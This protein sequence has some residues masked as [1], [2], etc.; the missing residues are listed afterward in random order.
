MDASSGLSRGELL[1]WINTTLNMHLHKIEETASGA[2]ACQIID[3]LYPDTVPL[4]RVNF[5]AKDAYEYTKNYKILQSACL[6]NGIQKNIDVDRLIKG[7]PQDN[8]EFMQWLKQ[9]FDKHR[10]NREYNAVERRAAAKGGREVTASSVLQ[11]PAA[12]LSKDSSRSTSPSRV[13]D[14]LSCPSKKPRVN[15]FVP[16]VNTSRGEQEEQLQELAKKVSEK[17]GVIVTQTLTIKNLEAE[18]DF[19][20]KKLVDIEELVTKEKEN[21][22]LTVAQLA[23][24]V[25]AILYAE[26]NSLQ[27]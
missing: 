5:V 11:P 15:V 14:N 16:P 17:E 24:R 4:Q 3:M 18:R 6:K 22:E 19:Y 13:G 23:E 25:T 21:G 8:L 9:Y 10:P 12:R 7:R 2:V 27:P 26:S 1:E 20:K